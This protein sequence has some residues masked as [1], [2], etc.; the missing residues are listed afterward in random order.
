ML[1]D[2]RPAGFVRLTVDLAIFTVRDGRLHVLLIER[3]NSP[4]KG[5]PALPGGFL[6]EDEDLEKAALRELAEETH[7][8]GSR[9]LLEQLHT[10]ADLGRDSRG[11][12]VTVAYLALAPDLPVPVPGSDAAAARWAPV[13]EVL[14]SRDRLAFDHF[15]II[16]DAL[17]RVRAMLETT[18]HATVFCGGTF[19]VTELRLVYEAVWSM[20]LDPRNFSRRVLEFLEPVEEKRTDTHGRPAKLYRA[21]PT[22]VLDRPMARRSLD[23]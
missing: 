3:G 8:D 15:D 13:D 19:T 12:V 14:S 20:K 10:Y 7:L 22:R 21:G 5:Q 2:R 18:T 9:L 16:T 17:E 23:A 6:R 11:R 4:H 1:T